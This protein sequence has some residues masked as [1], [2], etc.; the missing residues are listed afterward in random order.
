M[1]VANRPHTEERWFSSL[2]LSVDYSL[3]NAK[4]VADAYPLPR[5]DDFL[6]S[7]GD[8]QIFTTLDFNVGY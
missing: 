4:N 3:L 5:I 1:G 2:H 8:V 7:L 6:D